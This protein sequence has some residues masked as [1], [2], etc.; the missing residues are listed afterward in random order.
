MPFHRAIR[1][2]ALSRV[3]FLFTCSRATCSACPLFLLSSARSLAHLAL[4]VPSLLILFVLCWGWLVRSRAPWF[5]SSK[6]M[7]GNRFRA[8][9]CL[10]KNAPCGVYFDLEVDTDTCIYIYIYL[11]YSHYLGRCM[12]RRS[13]HTISAIPLRLSRVLREASSGMADHAALDPAA[14]GL[15]HVRHVQP[16]PDALKS[17]TDTIRSPGAKRLTVG[18]A[19]NPQHGNGASHSKPCTVSKR[20]KIPQAS[21]Y[22]Y[23]YIDIYIYIY[24]STIEWLVDPSATASSGCYLTW[25][26]YMNFQRHPSETA[27]GGPS[28]TGIKQQFNFRSNSAQN[29]A[30]PSYTFIEVNPL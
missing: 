29:C 12:N 10:D 24:I 11:F 17:S 7:A 9:R 30:P 26:Q 27:V 16:K 20:L 4:H 25:L 13:D 23:I 1:P 28:K 2:H 14:Y 22:I 21:M 6:A 8:A 18:A 5:S 19:E 3:F 15:G